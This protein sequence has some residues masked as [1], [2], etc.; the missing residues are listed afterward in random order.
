MMIAEQTMPD[1]FEPMDTAMDG[2]WI[3]VWRDKYGQYSV[4]WYKNKWTMKTGRVIPA[5]ELKGW[6]LPEQ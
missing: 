4:R 3:T 5:D 6:K 2:T 1:G